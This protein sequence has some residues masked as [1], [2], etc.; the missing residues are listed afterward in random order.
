MEYM[1]VY[2]ENLTDERACLSGSIIEKKKFKVYDTA[3]MAHLFVASWSS[4]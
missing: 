4:G 3:F 2:R 1:I